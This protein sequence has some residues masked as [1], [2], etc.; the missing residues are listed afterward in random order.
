MSQMAQSRS[1][2]RARI[3]PTPLGAGWEARLWI[4]METWR[5]DTALP[6][7]RSSRNCGMPVGWLLIQPTYWARVRRRCSQALA[8]K[9]EPAVDGVTTALSV[10]TRSE[11]R[12]VGKEVSSEGA[13]YHKKTM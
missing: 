1:H 12:R 11:E 6:V 2:R 9:R 3:S 4:K 8:V 10:L 7:Q 13:A 5:S